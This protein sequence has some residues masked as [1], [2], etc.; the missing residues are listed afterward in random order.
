MQKYQC[1]VCR[2][3]KKHMKNLEIIARY[4]KRYKET[5][6]N[7]EKYSG[8]YELIFLTKDNYVDYVDI[9]IE[10]IKKVENGTITITHFSDILRAKLLSTYGGVWIDSTMFIC[11]EVFEEFDNKTFN[12]SILPKYTDTFSKRLCGFFMGGKPNLFFSFLYDFFIEYNLK[13]DRLVNY[14][15]IDFGIEIA[16]D[17]FDECKD[18]FDNITLNNPELLYFELNIDTFDYAKF[19][20][21][22]NQYKFFKVTQKINPKLF[23]DKE[24]NIT[25]SGYFFINKEN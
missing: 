15:L 23:Y 11:G 24:G 10:I 21:L 25:Y 22:C 20:S 5:C 3:F 14:F 17:S 2:G 1:D 6:K 4:E 19:K 8:T 16:Y 13:Y 9:P 7:I 18:Y 12:S